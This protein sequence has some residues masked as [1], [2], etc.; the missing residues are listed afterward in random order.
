VFS[1]S[2]I[3][4]CGLLFCGHGTH[5]CF[6]HKHGNAPW[7]AGSSGGCPTSGHRRRQPF[8]LCLHDHWFVVW[9]NIRPFG[10]IFTKNDEEFLDL[11]AQ[12]R[13]PFTVTLVLMNMSIAVEKIPYSMGRTSDVLWTG[14][15]ASWGGKRDC[16]PVSYILV[17]LESCQPSL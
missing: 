11:F 14:L 12:T 8:Q 5:G 10:L 16:T 17:V 1:I 3:A 4:S 2:A 6:G 13:T 9:A 15:I 7:K